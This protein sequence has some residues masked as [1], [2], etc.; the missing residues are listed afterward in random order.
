[1]SE[2]IQ[3]LKDL[4]EQKFKDT[5]FKDNL[6]YRK[7][8]NYEFIEIETQNCAD[9]FLDINKSGK[10]YKNENNLLVPYLLGICDD[11]NIQQMPKIKTNEFPDVDID[12]LATVR[13]YLKNEFAPKHYKPENT[14][15]IGTYGRYALKSS[16]LDM[17]RIYGLD[18]QEAL[19]ITTSLRLRDEDGEVMTYE[20]SLE[21][22][23]ELKT[24]LEKY[25]Q[26]A[27]AIQK[28]MNR[29]RSTGKHAGGVIVC[30][31]AVNKFV[32]LMKTTGGDSLVSQYVE[33]LA[34]QE[35]GPIGL[36]KFDLLVVSALEQLGVAARL[37]KD[38]HNIA[39]IAG[40][41]EDWDETDYLNDP[42]CIETA[43]N[44]DLLG[45]FQYD[46]DGIREVVKKA[47]I[48]SF[49]DLVA[50]V[51]LYRPG[52]LNMKM[53]ELF[54]KRKRGIELYENHPLLEPIL[55]NTYGILIYQEQV[56]KMLNA[57]GKIPLKDCETIRKAI[58]KKKISSF[59]KYKEMFIENGI[60]TLGKS[61]EEMCAIFSEIESF[62]AYGF[63]KTLTE[64]TIIYCVDGSKQIKDIRAGDRVYC[65]NE[66]G[67]QA[68]TE[69]VAVHDH[70]V[71]DVVEVIFDDGYS[72]KC[73]LD[74][75]FLTEEGQIPLWE[76]IEGN[77][78]VLSSPLGEQNAKE[79]KLGSFLR[80]DI[81]QQKK[82][83][84]TS[85]ELHEMQRDIF[86]KEDRRTQPQI[87]LWSEIS[88]QIQIIR[89]FERVSGLY[90]SEMERD[91]EKAY[92]SMRDRV[93][94]RKTVGRASSS[95]REMHRNKKEEY[96]RSNGQIKQGQF[97]TREKSDILRNSQKNFSKERNTRSKSVAIE[98]MERREPREIF[99]INFESTKISKEIS[100]GNLGSKQIELGAGIYPL[101]TKPEIC[102]FGQRQ[103]L[104]RSRWMFSLLGNKIKKQQKTPQFQECSRKRQNAERRSNSKKEC[105]TF[106]TESFA[107]SSKNWRNAS[108][109]VHTA[110]EYATITN[111][112]S[113]VSRR[114]LRVVPV[115]KRQCYDLEVA[116]STH[117]FILPNGVVT[118]NSHATAYTFTS[119]RQLYLK[120]YF[121][122][123]FYTALLM[124][125]T[126]EEKIRIYISDA[127]RHG[128]S[129]LSLDLNKS[130]DNFSIQDGK[131]YIGFGNIKG[132]G[133]D[134]AKEIV[135]LQPFTGFEDFITRFGT[136]A[137][138]LR[139]LIPLR[140]FDD[141][142][143]DVLYK[144]WQYYT[145]FAK[146][147]ND[148]DKRYA[149]TVETIK[150]QMVECLPSK[151]SKMDLN[152]QDVYDSFIIA[153]KDNEHVQK[154]HKKYVKCK[155]TFDSKTIEM[156]YLTGF[157]PDL[158]SID[159]KE[160]KI[161]LENLIISENKYYG[162]QFTN[163]IKIC[164]DYNPYF[165][166]AKF[167]ESFS[168]DK[169]IRAVQV[170]LL[171]VIDRTS[172]SGGKYC[173][174]LAM[175]SDF[176]IARINIW[177]EDNK[178][179][180]HYFKKG[181]LL[182]IHLLPPTNGFSTFSLLAPPKHKRYLLTKN[183][184]LD[185]RVV[186]LN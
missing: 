149:K 147:D 67:E 138:V 63:N 129:V 179:F 21:N 134:R 186:K 54:I 184:E 99:R 48:N 86:A 144:F 118:S 163:R 156:P 97:I 174:L 142:S 65:V 61:K 2:N 160:I 119:S 161:E 44:A 38:R 85:Q 78:V 37:I 5:E 182:S 130:K 165:T 53:D 14:C 58:S 131:I 6:T 141:E 66:K 135:R 18:R 150:K 83:S 88:N 146:K 109:M 106:Q 76:I 140:I 12:F 69:V 51:S 28:L 4:V 110:P 101:W 26:V 49:D 145:T 166:F 173:Q 20:E 39:V 103:Y 108:R 104:D 170:D 36:V 92:I 71:I 139:A 82:S 127:E 73:T 24:Y 79:I 45:V 148:R 152:N 98:E 42:R 128:I 64:D 126:D 167:L 114:V 68:Q 162:F 181:N 55:G 25:P 94:T 180:S 151:Y 125:E 31:D 164:K 74:H 23:S 84:G 16:L 29:I 89:S 113:L 133:E 136:D 96:S 10:K 132:I 183:A 30:N 52:P 19:N 123:E 121:P 122:I 7:R 172:K 77:L 70:G 171:D 93:F 111:T 177:E 3:I 9:Y 81:E 35:L 13:D 168:R 159:D 137:T 155:N 72:V 95:L 105:N 17:A 60:L 158:F 175:D 116:V 178:L 107:F 115:G 46:S 11:F 75:K 1:M 143:P 154:L 124:L 91:R 27:I 57:V 169:S 15:S 62:A 90:L 80:K 153:M 102:G 50:I 112:G 32:P 100:N 33:G 176:K 40:K 157:D 43:D 41:E 120:T 56:M 22:F 34:T 117:N 8:L 87:S 47:G 185:V 59:I